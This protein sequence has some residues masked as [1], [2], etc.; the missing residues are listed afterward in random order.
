MYFLLCIIITSQSWWSYSIYSIRVNKKYKAAG[1][2]RKTS[3]LLHTNLCEELASFSFKLEPGWALYSCDWD[4]LEDTADSL[5]MA[6]GT[7]GKT[8]SSW[9]S[10]DPVSTSSKPTP[11]LTFLEYFLLFN[12]EQYISLLFKPLGGGITDVFLTKA[13]ILSGGSKSSGKITIKATNNSTIKNSWDFTA[14]NCYK[15]L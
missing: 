10:W 9:D 12:K 1:S 7:H 6:S 15:A 4:W 14:R 13:I 11:P 3:L 8:S 5:S 2:F